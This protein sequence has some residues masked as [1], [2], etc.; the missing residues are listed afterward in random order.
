LPTRDVPIV[1]LSKH[2]IK[3]FRPNVIVVVED[4]G[5]FTSVEDVV[6]SAKDFLRELN[7]EIKDENVHIYENT[8]SG[9]LI[10]SRPY[11]RATMWH[12]QKMYLHQGRAY[13]VTADYVP[14]SEGSIGLFGGLQEIMNSFQFIT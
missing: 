9:I 7:F 3:M 2:M 4:V 10:G 1:A 14:I 12:V 6:S 11:L 5:S 13:Y 8:N